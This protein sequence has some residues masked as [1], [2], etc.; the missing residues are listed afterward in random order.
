METKVHRFQQG[1]GKKQA[2]HLEESTSRAGLFG[3]GLS[4]NKEANEKRKKL[5]FTAFHTQFSLNSKI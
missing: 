4:T 5:P 1:V 3:L 2:H